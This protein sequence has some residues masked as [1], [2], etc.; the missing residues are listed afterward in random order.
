MKLRK[1]LLDI[2]LTSPYLE[3]YPSIKNKIKKD[4]EIT[5][6]IYEI[7]KGIKELFIQIKKPKIKKIY[8]FLNK[9]SLLEKLRNAFKDEKTIKIYA[10]FENDPTDEDYKVYYYINQ[11]LNISSCYTVNKHIL[12]KTGNI[13]SILS[14]LLGNNILLYG[15]DYKMFIHFGDKNRVHH[16][17]SKFYTD[18]EIRTFF[19]NI[20]YDENDDNDD[21]LFPIIGI[22][23]SKLGNCFIII[24]EIEKI[25]N[26]NGYISL[27]LTKDIDGI[28]DSIYNK[29]KDFLYI[30]GVNT[31]YYNWIDLPIIL[32]I[33]KD[34]QNFVNVLGFENQN[35]NED[36]ID[37]ENMELISDLLLDNEENT[38]N[39]ENDKIKRKHNSYILTAYMLLSIFEIPIYA[40]NP[41]TFKIRTTTNRLDTKISLLIEIIDDLI[42]SSESEDTENTNDFIEWNLDWD[43]DDNNDDD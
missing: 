27:K 26:D 12:S 17:I 6:I 18:Q 8:K 33:H 4:P 7:E 38:N 40:I 36:I 31:G 20:K 22:F 1:S 41:S 16:F 35:Q 15:Y 43:D 23:P 42:R 3:N 14:I 37:A 30:R 24:K 21:V 10:T 9:I 11:Y 39:N 28:Y 29:M 32:F 25:L 5:G 19:P 13:G 2:L 34:Y